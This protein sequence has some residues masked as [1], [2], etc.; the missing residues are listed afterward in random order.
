MIHKTLNCFRIA[1]LSAA[2]SAVTMAGVSAQSA[3]S[4]YVY[5]PNGKGLAGTTVWANL[6]S[7]PPMPVGPL[8]TTVSAGDG[9]FTLSNVPSGDYVLCARNEG[10]A[11]LNPCAWGSVPIVKIATGRNATGQTIQMAAGATF[12]VHLDDPGGLL[13][14][15]PIKAVPIVRLAT[16]HGITMLPITGATAV[17]RDFGLLVPYNATY[18]VILSTEHFKTSDAAGVPISRAAIP[19]NITSGTPAY[20]ISLRVAGLE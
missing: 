3:I 5:G 7:P 6:V 1:I 15:N 18:S 11:A 19:V 2:L 20:S 16:K 9:S 8:L 17:S 13:A 14:A 10:A 4:G 12:A